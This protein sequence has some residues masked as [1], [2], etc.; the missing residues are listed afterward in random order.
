MPCDNYPDTHRR[1]LQKLR[2][3]IWVH[4]QVQLRN[5]GL[6]VTQLLQRRGHQLCAVDMTAET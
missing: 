6:V 2:C 3:V 4:G 5:R 1:E